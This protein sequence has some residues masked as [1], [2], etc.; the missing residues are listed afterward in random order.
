M[1]RS[2]SF[3]ERLFGRR[4]YNWSRED[5]ETE[6]LHARVEACYRTSLLASLDR[7]RII[8]ETV[9]TVFERAEFGASEPSEALR[10]GM[11]IVAETLLDAEGLCD[12]PTLP[13]RQLSLE[14]GVAFREQL[15][16]WERQLANPRE[17][18]SLWQQAT[19]LALSEVAENLPESIATTHEHAQL[20][21]QA[22]L[23]DLL[24]NPLHVLDEL[25]GIIFSEELQGSELFTLV[26]D[27]VSYNIDVLCGDKPRRPSELSGKHT[28]A[29]LAKRYFAGT[30][31]A[32]L[33]EIS[34]PFPLPLSRRFEHMHIVGGSG[35]GKT[36][37]LQQ[38]LMHDL[39]ALENG[40]G[41]IIVID[42]QGDMIRAIS[43][44]A[45]LSP[46]SGTDLYK[47][48]VIIDPNDV[49]TPPALNLF[50]F[51]LDRLE[52]YGPAEREKLINGAIALYEYLFG[53]LL[54]AELTQRQGVIFRYLARLLMV[55][56]GATIHTLR[57]LMEDPEATRA[58]FDRLDP[59]TRHFFESQFL[60]KVFDDTRQQILTRLWGILSNS[61]LA[62]MFSHEHNKLNLFEAMN[63]GR[64]ILINT[65]K[66]LLKQ[67]GCAILGRFFIALIAQA[68]QERAVIP[69]DRRRATFLYVDE[70]QDYFDASIEQLLNQARKYKV[71]LI[72]AHQ[73]LE[74]FERS[75][76]AAVMASTAVKVAGGVSAKDAAAFA[77]EMRCE[78]EFLQSMRKRRD[79]TEFACFVRNMTTQPVRVAV[80]FGQMECEP[81]MSEDEYDELLALNRA[82][83]CGGEVMAQAIPAKASKETRLP[84]GPELL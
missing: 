19:M 78:P 50:D 31:L 8:R 61:V 27:R 53:A 55:V 65:A 54:G 44:L 18:L 35:H 52:R 4:R 9:A 40:R 73:N 56:P 33:F 41:S 23:V 22:S 49:E 79:R 15:R 25:L 69:A 14:E 2:L 48:V 67:E 42:S 66:D 68:A 30:P 11:M 63:G 16:T 81:R 71:G 7:E 32:D 29:E 10:I 6:E 28:P 80:P 12:F 57:Q 74:Q 21:G 39:A 17:H 24:S 13:Q 62:R 37:L 1:K 43:H 38:L 83:Y 51:G 34:L 75:L 64:L 84:T 58:Y 45:Q 46:Q 47:R 5:R 82:R 70:A 20:L 77:R 26:R 36:Q 59:L 3:S 72:L 60:S 76:L